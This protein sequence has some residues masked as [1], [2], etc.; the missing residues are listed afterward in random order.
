MDLNFSNEELLAMIILVPI[1]SAAL[2]AILVG[3]FTVVAPHWQRWGY[4]ALV[5]VR[6]LII[7]PASTNRLSSARKSPNPSAYGFSP[8]T[9][10]ATSCRAGSAALASSPRVAPGE[11]SLIP[12]QM[13]VPT[14][15]SFPVSPCQLT[16]HPPHCAPRLWAL[17]PAYSAGPPHLCKDRGCRVRNV[18]HR[19]LC[20]CRDARVSRARRLV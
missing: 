12:C 15:V 7:E 4:Y 3:L 2:S 16:V 14:T 11:M 10:I 19:L 8:T 13:V 6:P 17:R 5:L 20:C 1:G 9:T 18:L